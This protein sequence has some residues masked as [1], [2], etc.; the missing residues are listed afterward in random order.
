MLDFFLFLSLKR[1]RELEAFVHIQFRFLLLPTLFSLGFG[2]F[3]SVLVF[4]FCFS[5]PELFGFW[6]FFF[7]SRL[8]C[9]YISSL[10]PFFVRFSSLLL[11]CLVLAFWGE[12]GCWVSGEMK[13]SHMSG[14]G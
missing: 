9:L 6:V 5:F 8:G 2:H 7:S 4:G 1:E 12:R 13:E 10:S 14:S 11:I 3:V